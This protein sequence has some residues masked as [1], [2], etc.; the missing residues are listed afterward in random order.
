[1]K[2]I[3]GKHKTTVKTRTAEEYGFDPEQGTGTEVKYHNTIVVYFT[4]EHIALDT[5]GYRTRAT[6]LRMN[7]VSQQFDLGY[8][9]YQKDFRWHVEF[10]GHTTIFF[11]RMMIDRNSGMGDWPFIY[12][13]N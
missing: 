6:K 12:P 10:N 4:D 3:I 9:I 8:R 11:N 13:I 7:Q 1:M 2:Q 5:G